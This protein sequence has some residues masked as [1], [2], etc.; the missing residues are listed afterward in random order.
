MVEKNPRRGIGPLVFANILVV[1][2]LIAQWLHAALTGDMAF[3]GHAIGLDFVNT[4]LGAKLTLAG[5]VSPLFDFEAYNR[6]LKE[7]FNAHFPNHMWSYP[8]HL[9]PLVAPLGALPYPLAYA[10]WCLGTWLLF[11]CG[12]RALGFRG[13]DLL[14]LATSPAV[15][16]NIVVGQ[17]GALTAG[18]LTLALAYSARRPILAG[19]A[20]ALLTVKPQFGLLVPIEWLL[21]RRFLAIAVGTVVTLA[22]IGLSLIVPG[23]VAW[24]GF[25]DVTMPTMRAVMQSSELAAAKVMQPNWAS[26]LQLIGL[27][28]G[29]AM[30]FQSVVSLVLV[31]WWLRISW[32]MRAVAGDRMRQALILMASALVTPYIHNYDLVLVSPVV[33]WA[34][35]DGEVLHL[36]PRWRRLLLILVWLMPWIMIPLHEARLVL[37]PVLLTLFTILLMRQ[38]ERQSGPSVNP[39]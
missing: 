17:T 33:I 4:W 2:A 23:I 27:P 38:A 13:A 24:Q 31:G 22:L 25:F 20:V 3:R 10:V 36:P 12:S 34:W 32:K 14:L 28:Y 35:R 8:P 16:M 29:A 11:L 30:A 7:I 21:R 15:T 18:C 26:G 39:A 5:D 1:L 19:I 9:L 6:L 37:A